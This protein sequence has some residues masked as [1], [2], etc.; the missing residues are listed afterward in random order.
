MYKY[1]KCTT[2]NG[3]NNYVCT[4]DI[5]RGESQKK[6]GRRGMKKLHMGRENTALPRT[7]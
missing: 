6:S 1:S 5:E 2:A 7:G 3:S 4:Q